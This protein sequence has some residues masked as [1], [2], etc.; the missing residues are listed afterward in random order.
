[1]LL[2][3]PRAYNASPTRF[4][5]PP[6]RFVF[7]EMP[8]AF[9][10]RILSASASILRPLS[11]LLNPPLMEFVM[12]RE[13]GYAAMRTHA[14]MR[15]ICPWNARTVPTMTNTIPNSTSI[16]A[17]TI[18]IHGKTQIQHTIR[19]GHADTPM[20]HLRNV[21]IA[22]MVNHRVHDG[23]HAI[24]PPSSFTPVWNAEEHETAG[25]SPHGKKNKA[26]ERCDAYTRHGRWLQMHANMHANA[27]NANSIR[28]TTRMHGFQPPWMRAAGGGLTMPTCPRWMAA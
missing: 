3:S 12:A 23:N 7:L 2:M 10:H 17:N 5:L 14:I 16:P 18:R 19:Q 27:N 1:M 6:L 13:N 26:A 22:G 21:G 8:C 11:V 25:S 20:N 15:S 4:S 28:P 9:I 24:P